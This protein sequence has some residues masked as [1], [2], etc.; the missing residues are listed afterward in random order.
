MRVKIITRGQIVVCRARDVFGCLKFCKHP[1]YNNTGPTTPRNSVLVGNGYG[2]T[3]RKGSEYT[4]HD[5]QG[6]VVSIYQHF[7]ERDTGRQ[8]D[9]DK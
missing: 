1:V 4:N 3:G 8:K 2:Q 9:F 7:Q 5:R 6:V